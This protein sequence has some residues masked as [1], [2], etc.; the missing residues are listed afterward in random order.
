[1]IYATAQYT[2]PSS[3][4]EAC[5]DAARNLVQHIKENEPETL[6]YTVLVNS[7]NGRCRF[8][9][10]AIFEG[11][12]AAEAHKDSPEFR[13]FL[14]LVYPATEQGIE[15]RSEYVVDRMGRAE[16]RTT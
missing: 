11:Q 5:K 2:V 12:G 15:F 4:A 1:M 9:H 13:S 8:L 6:H 14:N 10:V 3:A 7:E 16:L